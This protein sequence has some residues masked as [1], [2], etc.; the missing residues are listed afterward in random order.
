VIIMARKQQPKPRIDIVYKA[1]T[2]K[3]LSAAAIARKTSLPIGAVRADLA[4]LIT[5]GKAQHTGSHK[6]SAYFKA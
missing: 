6:T 2:K 3:G 4:Q 5:D 1:L